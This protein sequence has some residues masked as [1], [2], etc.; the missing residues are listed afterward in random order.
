MR[1]TTLRS[2][3]PTGFTRRPVASRE[4]RDKSLIIDIH[5]LEKSRGEFRSSRL[6]RN[7]LVSTRRTLLAQD[8]KKQKQS[9]VFDIAR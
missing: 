5:E 3:T 7:K 6:D 9:K 2:Q 8:S 1:S 4:S